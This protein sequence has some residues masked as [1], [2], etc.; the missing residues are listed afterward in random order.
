VPLGSYTAVETLLFLSGFMQAISFLQSSSG[1]PTFKFIFSFLLKRLLKVEVTYG[2]NLVFIVYLFR[3][4]G[5]GGPTW[6]LLDE[7]MSPCEESLLSNLLFV[8]NFSAGDR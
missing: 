7:L 6:Y 5:F 2:F 8:N 1:K 4:L 3:D